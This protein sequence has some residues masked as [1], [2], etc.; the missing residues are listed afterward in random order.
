M[1][2]AAVEA[3]AE[4]VAEAVVEAVVEVVVMVEVVALASGGGSGGGDLKLTLIRPAACSTETCQRELLER[5]QDGA[6]RHSPRRPRSHQ[7][8][9]HPVTDHPPPAARTA[10]RRAR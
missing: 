4:A 5:W 9:S 10:A 7:L 8:H 2:V 6:N 1:S 3:V